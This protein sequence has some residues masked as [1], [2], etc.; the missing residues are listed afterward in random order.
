MNNYRIITELAFINDLLK[1]PLS[2]SYRQPIPVELNS[3]KNKKII[4]TT[5]KNQLNVHP[6]LAKQHQHPSHDFESNIL[7][8]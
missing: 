6:S 8:S 2:I 1:L 7:I 4:K 3:L 5:W